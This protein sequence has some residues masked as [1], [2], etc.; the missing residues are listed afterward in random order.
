M[1]PYQLLDC[2]E[3]L[4]THK[5]QQCE[6]GRI[7]QLIAEEPIAQHSINIQIDIATLRVVR[8]QRKTHRIRTALRDT[9]REVT[10]LAGNRSINLLFVQIRVVE[11]LVQIVQRNAGNHVSRI[12]D[13]AQRFGHLSAVSVAHHRMK[14][15]L[16]EGQF[17]E[18]LLAEEHHASDPE[19]DDVVAGLQQGV[20]EERLHVIR[21]VGPAHDGERKET[22]T[23]PG[24]EHI[25]V[26]GEHD[27]GRV[28]LELGGRLGQ[29]LLFGTADNPV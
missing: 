8:T 7:P 5:V 24:V 14:E 17:A 11:L 10:F 13:V 25:F 1:S 2:L 3:F 9:V 27:L 29:S 16:L 18:Q 22:R 20:W 19:E 4:V 21:V 28:H 26:L 12:D 6:F 15:D 23:E